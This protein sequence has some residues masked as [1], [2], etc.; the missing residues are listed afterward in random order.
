MNFFT[1]IFV[2]CF[3]IDMPAQSWKNLSDSAAVYRKQNNFDKALGLF[4]QAKKILPPDSV[5]SEATFKIDTAIGNIYYISKSQFANAEDYYL[6][7]RQVTEKRNESRSLAFASVTNLLGQVNYRQIRYDKAEAYYLEAMQIWEML[8]G[9][10]SMEY[11]IGCNALGILYNDS[12][13]FEKAEERHFEA[14]AI[15]EKLVGR[16]STA[17]AQS[18]N[19]LAAIYWNLGKYEKAEPLSLE[20]KEIRGRLP[21]AK[22]AYAIS[23]VNLANIYRDMGKYEQAEANYIEARKIRADFFTKNNN[24]YA[25]SCDILADL[26]YYMKEYDKAESL[27]L[28]SKTIREK[29]FSVKED[30]Y[31]QSCNNLSALYTAM[32]KYDLAESLALEANTI[33]NGLGPAAT[34]A[35]AFNNNNL[36]GLYFSL[37]QYDKAASY[38]MKA[39]ET[40]EKNLGAFHPFVTSN[41][42]SLARVY[43]LKNDVAK[44][45]EM[46][47][48]AFDAQVKQSAEI[49]S[50]TSEDEKQL[51]LK[52]ITGAEDEYHSFYYEK[53]KKG[54]KGQPYLISLQKR[55]LVL[56]SAQ[57][58]RQIIYSS[59]DPV[60]QKKYDD[61]T[62]L[63]K[64]VAALYSKGDAA[65]KDY[66]K[67]VI[68]KA[69]SL[70]KNLV[71]YTS[72]LDKSISTNI[73]WR[74]IQQKLSADEAAIEFIEFNYHNGREFTD[75]IY[76]AALVLRKE[77]DEPEYVNLFEKKE[78]DS[79][80]A[81]GSVSWQ[82]ING[83]YT[84]GGEVELKTGD[85]ISKNGYNLIWQPLE[86]KLKGIV[87]I[88]FAPAGLLH[89]IS[90]AALSVDST[91]V[92][93]DK[94]QL[95]QLSSTAAIT[96]LVKETVAPSEKIVLFGGVEYTKDPAKK[97]PTVK[98][99]NAAKRSGFE[100][101]PGTEKEVTQIK[102]DGVKNKYKPIVVKG[103]AAK[104]DSVKMLNGKRSPAILHIATHGFFFDDPQKKKTS[105]AS[106]SIIGGKVFEKSDNPLFRA[107]L[108]FAGA[109]DTWRGKFIDST[110]D[111]GILTAYELS[112]LYLPNTRL[113]VLSAC[114]TALGDIK[115]SEGVYGLQRALKMAGVKNLIMSLWKVP[116]DET[117][118]FMEEFYKKIFTSIPIDQAFYKTQNSLRDKYRATPYKWAAWVLIR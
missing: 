43:W 52:N 20:A 94:Y 99:A 93:S 64:Q 109:N 72:A 57:Q 77:M 100:Y 78:L 98:S 3:S 46:Y 9:K 58:M 16:E 89:R 51:Y 28:E 22:T 7:A 108:L 19:N 106:A 37:K 112:D 69:D 107:G 118:E 81:K 91:H 10:T 62:A 87:K 36:A 88:Y 17:Y 26:Y 14:R 101:L 44:A 59:N 6:E 86:S 5:Y 42:L 103:W 65:P 116:D 34:G 73:G 8:R 54:S 96:T 74:T 40:W 67:E 102:T 30:N 105:S 84:R 92:L 39:R 48:S 18:C 4:I 76:Y 41:T 110:T 113:V 11:A 55:N 85:N 25:L 47:E 31:A 15:R 63:K 97:N 90:F 49:F 38:F 75:S 70:E 33:L 82:G 2:C 21:N 27:Y 83:F 1:V 13:Q 117:A 95:V 53:L 29:I 111:D 68:R 24:D 23:C 35:L 80:L 50:F 71:R 115:G 61:W 104:E 79:L 60:L 45:A 66:L 114:E 56:S 32:G 12:G